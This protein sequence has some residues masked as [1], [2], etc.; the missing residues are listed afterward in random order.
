MTETLATPRR[1]AN[2]TRALRDVTVAGA[3]LSAA[4]RVHSEDTIARAERDL[5][6]AVDW[7]RQLGAQWGQIGRA[8][9]IARGNAYKRYRPKNPAPPSTD[10]PAPAPP[11]V[12]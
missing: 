12:A 8:L 1:A 10:H 5:R 4:K 2:A 9:G 6:V 7:A 3:Q 11:S